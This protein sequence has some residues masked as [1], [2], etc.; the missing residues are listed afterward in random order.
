MQNKHRESKALDRFNTESR[1]Y[2]R[3]TCKQK[4]GNVMKVRSTKATYQAGET[5]SKT[6]DY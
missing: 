5:E 3:K 1:N 4:K 2:T 6:A